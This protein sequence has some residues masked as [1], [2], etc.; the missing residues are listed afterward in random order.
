M[1]DDILTVILFIMLIIFGFGFLLSQIWIYKHE[2]EIG[3]LRGEANA[4]GYAHYLTNQEDG[5]TK[6]E[7]KGEKIY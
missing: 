7:W 5:T 6:W 4:R 3:H 2:S 1:K